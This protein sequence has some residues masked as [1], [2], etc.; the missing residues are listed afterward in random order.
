[1]TMSADF[2]DF[3]GKVVGVQ[4]RDMV[5]ADGKQQFWWLDGPTL[6]IQAGRL[7]LLGT[8]FRPNP[9]PPAW[10]DGVTICIPWDNISYYTTETVENYHNNTARLANIQH[11]VNQIPPSTA[12]KPEIGSC[13]PF[14]HASW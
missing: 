11:A 13:A 4:I 3:R 7:V 8:V 6:Q 12:I 2:P 9:G 14:T 1:M 5:G 10:Y